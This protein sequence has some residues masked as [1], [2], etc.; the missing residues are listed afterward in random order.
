MT[1]PLEPC[2]V[3]Q[4]ESWDEFHVWGRECGRNQEVKS[5]LLIAWL[6]GLYLVDHMKGCCVRLIDLLIKRAW[7]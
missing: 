5:S 4:E 7:L 2:S 1:G 6:V 3:N